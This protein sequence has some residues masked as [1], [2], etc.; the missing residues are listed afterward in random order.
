MRRWAFLAALLALAPAA[1][2]AGR[3]TITVFAASD[4][5]FAF[6]E[7]IPPVEQALGV[8]VAV[9]LGS[10]GNLARQIEQGAPA[11]LFFAA[12]QRFVERLVARG[13]LMAETQA[14]YAQG[15]I[16]LATA[17]SFG[18]KLTDLR[19]LLN[20][21][22]RH[23][24]ISNPLHAPYGRAAE[25]AL[26]KAGVW[27]ALTP[28]LVYGENV[29]HALQ[30][31]Q[32]G[33]A[34]AGI[35]ARSIANVPEIDWILI[36]ADLHAP[37]NQTAAVVKRSPRPELGLAFIRFVNGPEGRAIMKRYGFLLPGEFR[38]EGVAPTPRVPTPGTHAEGVGA[39][40]PAP[41][42]PPPGVARAGY[43][44]SGCSLG[45]VTGRENEF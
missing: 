32:T 4:L 44:R 26:R 9:V 17:K 18:P 27:E 43:P 1:K 28:K 8:K 42:E 37:L 10:T 41:S 38:S 19:A 33:G 36:D 24:A 25:E 16:A 6:K 15:R 12:D 14:L 23:V 31:I 3:P 29:R 45:P 20:P 21:R 35:V 11:D 13:I 34:E 22:V 39:R 5:A 40:V 7:V 2:A 30:F